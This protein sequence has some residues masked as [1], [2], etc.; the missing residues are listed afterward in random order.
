MAGLSRQEVM[1]WSS[2]KAEVAICGHG[3]VYAVFKTVW[4]EGEGTGG[5]GNQQEERR[6]V[7]CDLCI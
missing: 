3:L 4:P 2:V 6:Q 5:Q 7:K 1:D